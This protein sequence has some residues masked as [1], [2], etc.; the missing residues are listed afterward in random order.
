[1]SC[2]FDRVFIFAASCRKFAVVLDPQI[3]TLFQ[4]IESHIYER[5][6]T[7]EFSPM[8]EFLISLENHIFVPAPTDVFQRI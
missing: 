2:P 5:C 6:G 4:R 8:Y 7:A 3:F 1:M